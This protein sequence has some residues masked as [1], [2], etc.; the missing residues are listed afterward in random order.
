[1]LANDAAFVLAG[2]AAK[3]LLLM[4]LG[5]ILG[6]PIA[7]TTA[8][9]STDSAAAWVSWNDGSNVTCPA[10]SNKQQSHPQATRPLEERYAKVCTSCDWF[11][12]TCT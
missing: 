12:R 11:K 10:A 7:A 5:V 6:R 8:L 1:L 3:L 4:L 2:G 9:S